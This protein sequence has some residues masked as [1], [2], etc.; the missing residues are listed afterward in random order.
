MRNRVGLLLTGILLVAGH[1]S[2]ETDDPISSIE[3]PTGVQQLE[4]PLAVSPGGRKRMVLVEGRCPGFSWGQVDGARMHELV[5]YDIDGPS[6]SSTVDLSAV[7]KVLRVRIPGGALAWTPPL[8]QCLEAGGSYAWTVRA[9]VGAT[10]TDWAE[11]RLFRVDS[12]PSMAKVERA[13][14]T[15]NRFV[16][17]NGGAL[18]S[19]GELRAG[20]VGPGSTAR[21]GS[22]TPS[23]PQ[24]RTVID[25]SNA[26][27]TAMRAESAAASGKTFGLHG[28]SVSPDAES[29]GVVGDATSAAG[30]GGIF[31]N[32]AA[33]GAGLLAIGGSA[34]APDI[35]LG[36]TDCGGGGDN[37]VLASDP[38]CSD[39]DIFLSAKDAVVFRIGENQAA[40]GNMTVEAIQNDGSGRKEVFNI[41]ESGEILLGIINTSRT[42]LTKTG[43]ELN[44]AGSSGEQTFDIGNAGPDSTTL[45]VDGVSIHGP[46]SV[47]SSE[48]VNDSLTAAD[49]GPGSVGSSEVADGSL[50]LAE[51]SKSIATAVPI[52]PQDWPGQ[53][54]SQNECTIFTKTLASVDA[55]DITWAVPHGDPYP[56]LIYLPA[57]ATNTN[58]AKVRVCNIGSTAFP[59]GDVNWDFFVFDD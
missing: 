32:S 35:I 53:P 31:K 29:A 22:S 14:E 19:A 23:S 39:S 25:T 36:N 8:S 28:A 9:R 34:S 48:V 24:T 38:A 2:G 49:L 4:P 47:G 42:R 40:A 55:G 15:L 58:Q 5:V 7:S 10:W 1:A 27:D 45:T 3:S 52:S 11:V 56:G 26:V 44:L 59:N 37:G 57:R 13:L 17:A 43:L 30:F 12:G 41:N 51:M 6:A 50:N 54:I 46:D 21:S 20:A 16:A 33:G 18:P